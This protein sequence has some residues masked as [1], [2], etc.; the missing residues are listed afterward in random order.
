MKS[1]TY[2]LT[3]TLHTTDE[4]LKY[5]KTV[6]LI[7]DSLPDQELLRK[8][9]AYQA[10][11]RKDFEIS[12]THFV[13]GAD[14]GTCTGR[15]VVREFDEGLE[16]RLARW[17][18]SN[19]PCFVFGKDRPSREHLA[20]DSK[21]LTKLLKRQ[22]FGEFK[23]L[24]LRL[25]KAFKRAT[26]EILANPDKSRKSRNAGK[27]KSKDPTVTLQGFLALLAELTGLNVWVPLRDYA[28][29]F[30][31]IVP[32]ISRTLFNDPD[33]K[34]SFGPA[35]VFVEHGVNFSEKLAAALSASANRSDVLRNRAIVI[36]RLFSTRLLDG[37]VGRSVRVAL[38]GMKT[39]RL[40]IPEAYWDELCISFGEPHM[41]R[42]D[43]QHDLE[44][45]FIAVVEKDGDLLKTFRAAWCQIDRFGS[46]T[47]GRYEH[48]LLKFCRDQNLPYIKPI[49]LMFWVGNRSVK[50]DAI[51]FAGPEMQL[52]VEVDP[53]N[54]GN[55]EPDKVQKKGAYEKAGV[56]NISLD[57]AKDADGALARLL[58]KIQAPKAKEGPAAA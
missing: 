42:D 26:K 50:P 45:L 38:T 9:H 21:L 55:E 47:Q 44:S 32:H 25:T 10:E 34:E 16:Y 7:V 31:E 39:A 20:I 30:N 27:L 58:K 28:V 23:Y 14:E 2:T 37:K 53:N 18:R 51:V 6:I 36:G 48:L 8:W 13:Q 56:E 49:N 35:T 17:P 54:S 5:T 15:V 22:P 12:C 57:L 3:A 11:Y 29:G 40:S 33:F 41:P 1:Y 52:L 46:V 19:H 4:S 24:R 43:H